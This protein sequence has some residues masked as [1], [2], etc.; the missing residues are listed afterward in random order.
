MNLRENTPEGQARFKENN[1]SEKCLAVTREEPYES[2]L[3]EK[4]QRK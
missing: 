1:L 2:Y 3:L 4:K